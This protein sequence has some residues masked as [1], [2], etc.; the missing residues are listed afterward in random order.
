MKQLDRGVAKEMIGNEVG[1]LGKT[2]SRAYVNDFKCGILAKHTDSRLFN[3]LTAGDKRFSPPNCDSRTSYSRYQV[4]Q[5]ATFRVCRDGL[6]SKSERVSS[7]LN[8][9]SDAEIFLGTRKMI[10]R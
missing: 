2:E 10:E 9:A 1:D 5:S 6:K 3:I 7:L 8:S 4:P